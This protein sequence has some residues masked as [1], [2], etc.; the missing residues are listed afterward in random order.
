MKFFP[1][2]KGVA[3]TLTIASFGGGAVLAAPLN[4][5]LLKS[6]FRAPKF[7]GLPENL[8]LVTSETGQR[9]IEIDGQ[10][11]EVVVAGAG[12][13]ARLPVDGLEVGA[14]LAGTGSTGSAATFLTLSLAYGISMSVGS[15]LVRVPSP[16]WLPPGY[17]PPSEGEGGTVGNVNHS[18][19]LK[20]PQFWLLWTTLFG[21]AIA[22]VTMISASK[23]MMTEVMSPAYPHI[24]NGA[25]A[26]TFVVA[27]SASNMFGRLLY[28]PT[29]DVIGRRRTVA[30][31][32]LGVPVAAAVPSITG[33]LGPG[34]G[35]SPLV[36]FYGSTALMLSFYGG[37]FAPPFPGSR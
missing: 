15:M 3:S 18:T 32:G 23:T 36:A 16:E 33:M 10:L 12:D 22:G 30:I 19:A 7:L 5:F 1:D 14:Y 34:V 8:S 4:E 2:R 26:S 21:N 35:V 17:T 28:G 20:T 24:V 13:L 27:L 9:L 11:R 37:I 31:F 6:N 25:F 29:S